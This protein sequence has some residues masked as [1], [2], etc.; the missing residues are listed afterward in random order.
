MK[1]WSN[2][3]KYTAV[4]AGLHGLAQGLDQIVLAAKILS[5]SNFDLQFIFIGDGLEKERLIKLSKSLKLDN[6]SFVDPQDKK[7]AGNMGFS[8]FSYDMLKKYILGAVPSKLYEAMASSC[9]IIFIGDGEPR[10]I[11]HKANCGYSIYPREIDNISISISKMINDNKKR[12]VASEN[13]RKYVVE[14]FN[15]EKIMTNLLE[16]F[17]RNENN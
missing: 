15:R 17:K 6:I 7:H 5:K 13:A 9:P 4:Y 16:D 2:G 1:K 3:K 10:E 8:R 14:N 12:K 11:I